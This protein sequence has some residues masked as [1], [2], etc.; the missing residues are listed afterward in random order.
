MLRDFIKKIHNATPA[1]RK[2]FAEIKRLQQELFRFYF[3]P[4]GTHKLELM[5]RNASVPEQHYNIFYKMLSLQKSNHYDFYYE[6]M[7]PPPRQQSK[8]RQ[9]TFG[10]Y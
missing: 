9:S 8:T 6:D 7:I 10:M 2:H 3:N 4:Y 5:L 1:K